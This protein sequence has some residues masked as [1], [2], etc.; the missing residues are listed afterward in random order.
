[1]SLRILAIDDMGAMRSLV[2]R[3]L[4]ELGFD[5]V[6]TASNGK[7][8]FDRLVALSD[9]KE[10][11]Y[12][13]VISDWNMQPVNGLQLLKMVRSNELL[14]ETLFILLTA[15]Q[16]RDNI[17]AA[18]QAEVDE[19][20]IK[21]FNSATIKAKLENLVAKKLAAIK[22]MFDKMAAKFKSDQVDGD[23]DKKTVQLIEFFGSRIN[24][25]KRV[26]P[27]SSRPL[28]AMGNLYQQFGKHE[29]AEKYFRDAVKMNFGDTEAHAHL[30]NTLRATGKLGE[31]LSELELAL[32]LNP[33][34]AEL[35]RRLG[36]AY[37]KS[38]DYENAI[39]YLAEA[40][41]GLTAGQAGNLSAL[42]KAKMGKGEAT[43]DAGLLTQGVTD[44][45]KAADLDP[46]LIAAQYNLMVA[47]KKL[48]KSNEALAVM[49]R[50]EK[51]EPSDAEGWI[52][53]GKAFLDRKERVKA[54]F[55]FKKAEALARNKFDACM[56]IAGALY[57]NGVIKEAQTFNAIAIE[58]NPSS[59]LAYNLS[60]LLHR[61]QGSLK[62]AVADYE[63]AMNLDPDNPVIEFNL[64]FALFKFGDQEKGRVYLEDAVKK[65]PELE[66]K[67]KEI[68]TEG[69]NVAR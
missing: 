57:D 25:L 50:I 23:A 14:S 3:T 24:N 27:W 4:N 46:S 13:L 7:E 62:E 10:K 68:I 44:I 1:M 53:L 29:E 20:V 48:G 41:A 28:T 43:R 33:N 32:R 55:A 56:E 42:G 21:P 49:E 15:E 52:A 60:G 58:Q 61:A 2:K 63:H 35:K 34:S 66:E 51:L 18:L 26:A 16:G 30:S 12:E 5:D 11:A 69:K 45:Q 54:V 64:G 9:I 22:V 39:K 38:N 47:Y 6:T 67:L 8:A 37:L 65:M 59:V 17:V 40:Q 19:Y 36:E 31:S